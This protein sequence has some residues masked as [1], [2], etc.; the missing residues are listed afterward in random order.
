MSS[1]KSKAGMSPSKNLPHGEH[2]HSKGKRADRGP[3]GTSKEAKEAQSLKSK[4]SLQSLPEPSRKGDQPTPSM[5]SASQSQPQ[6][7]QHATPKDQPNGTQKPA[8]HDKQLDP[9]ASGP[10]HHHGSTRKSRSTAAILAAT[11]LVALLT[12]VVALWIYSRYS[13]AQESKKIKC[14]TTE[15]KHILD[16]INQ[17]LNQDVDP[18]KDF[19]SYICH[20]WISGPKSGSPSG[21]VQDVFDVYDHTLITALKAPGTRK[22]HRFGLHIMVKLFGVCEDY[23]TNDKGTL[24]A[25]VGQIIDLMKFD[26]VLNHEQNILTFLVDESL[27]RNLNSIFMVRYQR[28]GNSKYL[29][30]DVGDTIHSKMFAVITEDPPDTN[31]N[32]P[33]REIMKDMTSAFL[34]HPRVRSNIKPDT[35]LDLDVDVYKA[36]AVKY[37]AKIK[38]FDEIAQIFGRDLVREFIDV[39]NK[40]APQDFQVGFISRVRFSRLES[41]EKAIDILEKEH[42]DVTSIYHLLNVA[43]TLLRFT[44]YRDFVKTHTELVPF[45]C[46]RAT[47]IAFTNTWQY[48]IA[49]LIGRR[50]RGK[51]ASELATRVRDM[52]LEETVFKEFEAVDRKSG[53]TVL[54][55]TRLLTYY[56]GGADRLSKYT[57]YSSWTLEGTNAFEMFIKVGVQER[58][59]LRQTLSLERMIRASWDQLKRELKFDGV[60]YLTVPTAFQIPPLLYFEEANEIP[61][62]INLGTLGAWIAKEMVRALTTKLQ[63]SNKATATLHKS[64][65]CVKKVATVQGLNLSAI[66]GSGLWYSEA[67]LWYYGLRIVHEGLRRVVLNMGESTTGDVWKEAQHYLFIRFCMT[68]C[69]SR[70][71]ASGGTPMTFKERCLVPVLSNPDFVSTFGC[72][73]SCASESRA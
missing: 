69:T 13:K 60:R 22:P 68:A 50:S 17:Q 62:Y 42:S 35:I 9:N 51:V 63:T 2:K 6:E 29:Q 27:T 45:M 18:C 64:L 39:I 32:T 33:Y 59:M 8:A 72:A 53:E 56:G 65:T 4:E 38:T 12:I 26:K 55:N 23:M 5:P 10:E 19:Y 14:K 54:R 58:L 48:L 49:D 57:D 37:P 41:L 24:S 25:A 20:K 52:A 61:L 40:N 15:C 11:A 71:G 36:L 3:K 66:T 30:I 47:R 21:F 28:T 7:H 31:T 73:G 43:T 46:L 16:E 34:T 67:V 1:R 44:A 70:G